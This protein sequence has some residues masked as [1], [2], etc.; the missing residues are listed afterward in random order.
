MILVAV[1]KREVIAGRKIWEPAT[2]W[3]ASTMAGLAASRSCQ[4]RPLLRFSW[5]SFQS[6]SPGFTVTT[7]CFAGTAAPTIEGREGATSTAGGAGCEGCTLRVV[8]LDGISRTIG[9]TGCTGTTRTAVEGEGITL[10]SA[11][12]AVGC[13]GVKPMADCSEGLVRTT[14]ATGC[15]GAMRTAVE[16]EGIT[17]KSG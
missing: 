15:A 11:A 14:G 3:L 7:F 4:R 1:R 17:P 13:E 8:G 2:I 9:A 10:R 6:E 12:G 5:A 16:G